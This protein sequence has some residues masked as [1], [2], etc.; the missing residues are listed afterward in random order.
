MSEEVLRE[1]GFEEKPIAKNHFG[2]RRQ[3]TAGLILRT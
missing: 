3:E 1:A 2:C